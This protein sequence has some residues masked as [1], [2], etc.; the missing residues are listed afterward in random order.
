MY[1]SAMLGTTELLT[2]TGLGV[3]GLSACSLPIVCA[4][5]RDPRYKMSS[6]EA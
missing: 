2:S 6:A 5:M 1:S 4:A 3:W